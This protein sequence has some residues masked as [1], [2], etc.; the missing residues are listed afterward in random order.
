[1]CSEMLP[2]SMI[3]KNMCVYSQNVLCL[4][5]IFL[6]YFISIPINVTKIINR[7][8]MY[9][10]ENLMWVKLFPAWI[11]AKIVAIIEKIQWKFN[12]FLAGKFILGQ[13]LLNLLNRL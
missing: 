7:R 1:M 6:K 8:L 9:P 10:V 11:K 13:I 2:I 4:T 5:Y 12:K 3:V